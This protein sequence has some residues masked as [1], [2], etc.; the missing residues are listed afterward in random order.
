LCGGEPAGGRAPADTPPSPRRR[1][2]PLYKACAVRLPC[3]RLPGFLCAGRLSRQGLAV[4]SAALGLP[5]R[6]GL[7]GGQA[8][9]ATALSPAGKQ[10]RGSVLA[11][12]GW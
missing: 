8:V 5:D 2:L 3:A 12:S 7:G 4:G 9:T 1:K 10:R 6:A 11:I